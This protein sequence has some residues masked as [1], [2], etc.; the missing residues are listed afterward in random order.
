MH[1]GGIPGADIGD[2][3]LAAHEHLGAAKVAQLQLMRLRVDQQ[4]LWLDVPV[5]HLHAVDVCQRPAH[6]HGQTSKAA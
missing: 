5:T 3:G 1:D 4:V 2:V 6:L